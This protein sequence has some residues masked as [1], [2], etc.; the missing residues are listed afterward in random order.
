MPLQ[1]TLL[2]P[3]QTK[4]R[5]HPILI[6]RGVLENIG[7]GLVFFG[8]GLEIFLI[9]V[10]IVEVAVAL[11]AAGDIAL[12]G[13]D[14]IGIVAEVGDG[15]DHADMKVGVAALFAVNDQAAGGRR[16]GQ[17]SHV[18]IARINFADACRPHRVGRT[19][20]MGDGF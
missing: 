15:G 11:D 6:M 9:A 12:D 14:D 4:C 2:K 17:A 1:N 5:N 10:F 3:R 8:A 20:L 7:G 13:L 16:I 18:L 19:V